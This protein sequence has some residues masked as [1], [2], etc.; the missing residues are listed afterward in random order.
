[1]GQIFELIADNALEKMD[2]YYSE[3]HVCNRTDVDLYDYQGKHQLEN[4]EIDD[5]IYAVCAECILTKNLFHICDF[6]YLKAIKSYLSTTNLSIQ[7]QEQLSNKL[8]QKYQKTPDIPIFM[9]HHDVP[10]CCNDIVEFI[11]YPAND[12]ELFEKTESYI[13]WEKG[14][15]NQSESY[16]FRRVGGPES[17]SDVATFRCSHCNKKYFTFQF[18]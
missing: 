16:D 8:I 11:G 2:D 12:N 3:C 9:Q 13:Y 17:L 7:E 18:T 4:G 15:K 14:V 10:L 5:D 1:M 6:E